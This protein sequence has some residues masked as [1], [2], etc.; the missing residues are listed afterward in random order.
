V[1]K[2]HRYVTL[3]RIQVNSL[4][5]DAPVICHRRSNA[6]SPA[7]MPYAVKNSRLATAWIHCAG[8]ATY[9]VT[10]PKH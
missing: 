10:E 4:Q 2:A 3:K 5:S 9:Q 6:P 1:Q 7:E 8:S